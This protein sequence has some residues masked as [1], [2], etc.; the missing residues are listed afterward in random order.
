MKKLVG[1]L[2]GAMMMMATSAMALTYTLTQAD[3]LNFVVLDSSPVL[4]S[5]LPADDGIGG[6]KFNTLFTNTPQTNAFVAYGLNFNTPLNLTGYDKFQL[7]VTNLNENP[8]NFGLFVGTPN[9]NT[10]PTSVAV[11]SST[12]LTLD[13]TSLTSTDLAN[14]DAIGLYV[15][16]NLPIIGTG[17]IADYTAEFSANPVPE[18]GTMVL[19][20]AGLLGLA[21]FGKRRMN[22]E[23]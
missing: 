12:T 8:W 5:A 16:A 6:V 2:V 22:K 14:I 11:G 20:G 17:G 7:S 4:Y 10:L 13:L 23:A 3:L 21:I 18:P 15:N 19:L 1:L 9:I